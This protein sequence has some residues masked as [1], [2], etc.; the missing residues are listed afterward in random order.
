LTRAILGSSLS[1]SFIIVSRPLLPGCRQMPR[2]QLPMP[3]LQYRVKPLDRPTQVK[4][5]ALIL[6]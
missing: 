6:L 5:Y 2:P 3:L 1:E 4:R